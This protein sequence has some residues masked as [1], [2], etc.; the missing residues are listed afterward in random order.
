MKVRLRNRNK[1]GTIAC[2]GSYSEDH[3]FEMVFSRQ[4]ARA[5]A[6]LESS[7]R[8]QTEVNIREVCTPSRTVFAQE[9]NELFAQTVLKYSHDLEGEVLHY[10]V[11]YL[12]ESS[13]EDDLKKTICKLAVQSHPDKNKHPQASTAFCM[14][15]EDTL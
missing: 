8:N 4:K 11:L 3:A 7:T 5:D 9:E 12:N 2:D 13:I 1:S 14:I 15:N 10:Y 6:N